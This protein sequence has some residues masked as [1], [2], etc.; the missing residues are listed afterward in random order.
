MEQD[1]QQ[2][3]LEQLRDIHMPAEISWWPPAIGWWILLILFLAA[4]AFAIW[5]WL[6]NRQKSRYRTLAVAELDAA[7]SQWQQRQDN[8]LFVQQVNAILKRTVAEGSLVRADEHVM[9]LT[10]KRWVVLLEQ[11]ATRD[12]AG[13]TAS[14]LAQAGYEPNP[15]VNIPELYAEIKGWLLHHRK[16]AARKPAKGE[17]A[18]A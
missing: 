18:H 8:A 2:T 4:G 11:Y 12:L 1:L 7:Y 3:L 10:G 16:P 6:Q 5:A 14:A 17:P 15:D 13:N 9:S